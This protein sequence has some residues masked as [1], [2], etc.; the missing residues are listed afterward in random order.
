M[1]DRSG[2]ALNAGA[3]DA[4]LEIE[5]LRVL[6]CVDS[7]VS[8]S[9]FGAIRG[10]WGIEIL[11]IALVSTLAFRIQSDQPDAIVIALDGPGAKSWWNSE[12]LR[13]A[14]SAVPTVLLSTEVSSLLKR[15]AARANIHSV[16]PLDI[17]ANQLETAIR[18]TVEGLAVTLEMPP[19]D[20]DESGALGFADDDIAEEP[21]AAHLTARETEV[22][23]LMA[24]GQ[25]NKEIAARLAISE[26]TSK[27]HVSSVL[28]KLGAASRTE[29]VT[30]GIMRGLVAI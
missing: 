14:L 28:S 23:R 7:S 12:P 21:L 15:R 3:Q 22:L 1:A 11:P 4:R 2:R 13:G 30:I 29:A 18:A 17:S 9:Y 26:H 5:V 19:L 25:G 24:L 16:L 27:F 20:V 8:S 6:P 10:R